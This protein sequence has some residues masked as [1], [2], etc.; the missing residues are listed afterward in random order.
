MTGTNVN[1]NTN[2]NKKYLKLVMVEQLC[3]PDT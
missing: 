2:F 1:A 3:N